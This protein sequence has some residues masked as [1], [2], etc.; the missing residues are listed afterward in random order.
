MVIG[1]CECCEYLV[2]FGKIERLLTLGSS[3]DQ[4]VF[5]ENEYSKQGTL[6]IIILANFKTLDNRLKTEE[7]EKR[8]NTI[9][10]I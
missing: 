2:A 8:S 7:I 6:L 10:T 9:T 1:I 5:K 4:N 3:S